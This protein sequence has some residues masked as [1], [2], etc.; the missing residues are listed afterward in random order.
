MNNTSIG[1]SDRALVELNNRLGRAKKLA[2]LFSL[3]AKKTNVPVSILGFGLMIATKPT[4][5][6]EQE[7]S[8]EE[9][10]WAGQLMLKDYFMEIMPPPAI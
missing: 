1:A 8:V 7:Y 5:I 2:L 6:G 4:M 10:K 9:L 3:Y